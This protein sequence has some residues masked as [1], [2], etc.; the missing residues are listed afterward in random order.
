M[1]NN[2]TK[3]LENANVLNYFGMTVS[4][5]YDGSRFAVGSDN[6][7]VVYAIDNFEVT[8]YTTA[9]SPPGY[10]CFGCNVAISNEH[11]LVSGF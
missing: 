3:P 8:N 9:L 10:S 11:F 6:G 1:K 2:I 4:I 5:T 7:V